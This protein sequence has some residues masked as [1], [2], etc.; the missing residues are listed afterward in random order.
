MSLLMTI[1][2]TLTQ[3]PPV[4]VDPGTGKG[5]EWGKAAPIGLLVIL[6]I[7]I[8]TFFL[9]RS[10]VRKINRVPA[11]FDSPEDEPA[12]ADQVPGPGDH[13]TGPVAAATDADA[14][15]GAPGLVEKR[16]G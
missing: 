13:P 7:V 6:L 15:T 1:A 10:M 2:T 4:E 14:G 8:A 5:P 9:M 3:D 16:S 11:S 12:A